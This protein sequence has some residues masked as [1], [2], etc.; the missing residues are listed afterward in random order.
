MRKT[1]KCGLD[2]VR[3]AK[4]NPVVRNRAGAMALGRRIMPGDLKAIGFGVAVFEADDYFRI[5]FGRKS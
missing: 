4:W 2:F 5:S 3:D 1:V